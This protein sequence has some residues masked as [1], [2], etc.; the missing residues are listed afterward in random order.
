M[1]SHSLFAVIF[2][3]KPNA[4]H[5]D[6]YLHIA[7]SLRPTLTTMPGFLENE[8]FRSRTRTGYLL[9]LSLWDDEK[10]L[11]RWRTLEQHHQAQARG[12]QGVLDDYR[13]RVGEATRV[14]GPFADRSVGWARQDHTEVGQAK[15]LTIIDGVL[16]PNASLWAFANVP[17]P[18]T[19]E[20]D[21]FE[22]IASEGRVAILTAWRTQ[23]EADNFADE[24]IRRN[25]A[26]ASVYAIRIIR[27]Y[28]RT[29]RREAP[30]YYPA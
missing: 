21:V 24:A 5:S 28:G 20:A 16:S 15:A 27:D 23:Q 14:A 1:T 4:D 11:V 17:R 30:Q 29:D 12:R 26:N 10:A 13:I 25:D 18:S 7:S 8:R 6:D 2:E 3:V 22:H 9:S 19:V